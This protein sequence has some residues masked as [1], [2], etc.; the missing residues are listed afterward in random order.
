[1][2]VP[3]GQEL[4]EVRKADEGFGVNLNTKTC[5]CKRWDLSGIPCIHVM[6]AYSLLNQDP[7]KGVSSWYSKQMWVNTYSHFIKPV[8]CS[9]IWVKSANPP[10]LPPKKRIMPGRPRKNRIKHNGPTSPYDTDPHLQFSNVVPHEEEL[11]SIDSN[12][13]GKQM[14]W[15]IL[16]L[17]SFL[18]KVFPEL[19][20]TKSKQGA[21]QREIWR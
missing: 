1:M 2:V 16:K 19:F 13:G 12:E 11:D 10:P 6:A 15:L 4:F 21:L 8:G 14:R 3:C 17:K 7:S 5:T 9:S 18:V 20:T